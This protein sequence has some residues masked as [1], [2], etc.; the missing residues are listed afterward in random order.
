M[1]CD[2][3]SLLTNRTRPP[4]AIWMVFG[5][6][7]AEVIVIVFEAGVGSVGVLLPPHPEDAA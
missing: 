6:T 4:I 1:K 5:L 2:R 3:V 7:P